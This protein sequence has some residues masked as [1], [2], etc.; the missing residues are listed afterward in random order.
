MTNISVH[1]T[2]KEGEGCCREE[3]RVGLPITWNT[4]RVDE[5]LVS[6]GELVGMK[7]RRR[8]RPGLRNKVHKT[9]MAM[10]MLA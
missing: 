10:S 4:V 6:V 3:S 9:G 5:L 2:E 1:D 8:R 7:V